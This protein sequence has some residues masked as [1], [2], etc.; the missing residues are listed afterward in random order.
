MEL[1]FKKTETGYQAEF[2]ASSDFNIHLE[3][4]KIGDVGVYQRTT[5]VGEYSFVEGSRQQGFGKAYDRDFSGVVY[6]KSIMVKCDNE[7]TIAE[8]TF[9]QI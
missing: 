3:A 6:P 2:V 9:V 4:H 5:S 7:P 8:V 1:E